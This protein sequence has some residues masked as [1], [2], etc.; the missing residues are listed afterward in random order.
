MGEYAFNVKNIPIKIKTTS[1][2]MIELS[3]LN[4]VFC[5][6]GKS[7]LSKPISIHTYYCYYGLPTVNPNIMIAYYC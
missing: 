5:I 1:I 6:S 7:I 3:F 2:I 4:A